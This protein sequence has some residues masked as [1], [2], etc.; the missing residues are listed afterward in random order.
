MSQAILQQLQQLQQQQPPVIPPALSDR[1][2]PIQGPTAQPD[3]S[4]RYTT[5]LRPSP[6]SD[7]AIPLGTWKLRLLPQDAAATA[8][9]GIALTYE[10]GTNGAFRD[11]RLDIARFELEADPQDLVPADLVVD[12]YIRL[13]PRS[14]VVRLLGPGLTLIMAGPGLSAFDVEFSGANGGIDAR[15]PSAR[16]S[17]P[18]F[19]IGSPSNEIGVAC[20][21]VL[22]DL[23]RD[24]TPVLIEALLGGAD[25]GFRGL[26]LEEL[27]LFIGDPKAVGTW[28]GNASLRDFIINFDPVQLTGTF[29]GEL[30]HA[31]AP[32]DPQVLVEIWKQDEDGTRV[33]VEDEGDATLPAPPANER[34]HRVR[35]VA[36]PNW[37]SAGFTATWTVPA[38]ATLE[39][40][41]RLQQLDLGWMRVGP[42]DY[43]FTV[44]VKD[45]RVPT[46][47]E[48]R[49]VI[50]AGPAAAPGETAPALE[51]DLSASVESPEPG[52]HAVHL[53][54]TLALSQDFTVRL[55]V[56]GGEGTEVNADIH[57][58]VGFQLLGGAGART[59]TRAAGSTGAFP[60]LTWNMRSG[61]GVGDNVVSVDATVGTRSVSRRLRVTVPDPEAPGSPGF[62]LLPLNDW[63]AA[64]GEGVVGVAVRD[65]LPYDAIHWTLAAMDAP[66][67]LQSDAAA[68][69]FFA[70]GGFGGDTAIDLAAS[71]GLVKPDLLT[72]G[73]LYRLTGGVS[74][75]PAGQ[76]PPSVFVGPTVL[77]G[78]AA[79]N[80]DP[81]EPLL[82]EQQ[83]RTAYRVGST[84]TQTIRFAFDNDQIQPTTIKSRDGDPTLGEINV[85]QAQGFADLYRAIVEF[86]DRVERLGL[87]GSA[88]T[89]GADDYNLGLAQRRLDSALGALRAPPTQLRTAITGLSSPL[90]MTSTEIAAAAAAFN[91]LEAA[92][93]LVS[94]SWGEQNPTDTNDPVDRRVFAV[95]KLAPPALPARS[96]RTYFL[97]RGDAPADTPDTPA[98]TLPAPTEHP[99][100]HAW[101]RSAHTEIELLRN[102]LVRFQIRLE[103]DF[104]RFNENDLD[105]AGPLNNPDGITTLFLQLRRDLS[106]SP[107]TWGWELDALA[108]PGDVDGF[109]ALQDGGTGD[110]LLGTAGGPAIALP[111]LTAV[112]G[113]RMGPTGLVTALAIGGFLQQEGI[114]DVRVLVWRGIRLKL[115]HG[116][117]A[118][119]RFS[120]AFDYDVQYAIDADLSH[121]GLPDISLRTD[122]S[123]P[124]KIGFRNVGVEII[125]LKTV[126]V[127]YDPSAGFRV[128][129]G[130]P[131]VF[132]LGEGLGRLLRVDQV[133]TGAGSPLWLE[134]ELGFALDVGIFSI[135]KLRIRISLESGKLF[136][137]DAAG[138]VH[139]D[140]SAIRL[141]DID[142]TISKIGIG[143]EVPGVLDGYG[144][145]GITS[146][147]P[148]ATLVEGEL[149][150]S[151]P[152]LPTLRNIFGALKIYTSADLRALYLALGAEFTPGLPIGNTGVSVYGLHGLLGVNMGRSIADPL[153][154]LKAPPVGVT[155][156]AKWVPARGSWAFGV[157]ATLGT[158]FD[159]GFCVNLKG[160]LLLELPGPRFVL[161]GQVQI[162]AKLP[163]PTSEPIGVLAVV[164]L[165]LEN[166]LLTIGIDMSL[167]SKPII[168]LRVPTEAYFN[169][170]DPR[171]WHLRFG[172]WDPLEKRI[173]VRV[174]DLFEA[175]GYFQI[176]GHGLHNGAL[177]LEGICIGA[178]AR[179]EIV[180]GVP[181]LLYLEA[182]AEA[183]AGL[184]LSPLYLEG[185]LSVGGSLHVGP[186]SIGADGTLTAKV[187]AS[188]PSFLV[189]KGEVC[190]EIDLW[191]TSIRKCAHFTLGDGDAETPDPDNPFAKA[192][193]LDRMT[194]MEITEDGGVVI[195]PLDAVF[196]LLFTSDIVDGRASPGTSL[197][198]DPIA[199][200]NQVSGDL[201]YEFTLT[202][203][204]VQ[205]VG[206]AALSGVQSA[207]APYALVS[208]PPEAADS[209]RTLRVLD[210]MPVAHPRQLDFASAEESTLAQLFERLCGGRKPPSIGCATFDEEPLGAR[211]QWL[212]D[213]GQLKPVR[214]IS[215]RAAALGAEALSASSGFEPPRVVTLVPVDFAGGQPKQHCLR[216]GHTG[217]RSPVPLLDLL[218]LL[219]LAPAKAKAAKARSALY[220]EALK[221]AAAGKPLP[222][223]LT[224]VRAAGAILI[225]LPD[226]VV[227]QA[228]FVIPGKL[229]GDS[230]EIVALGPDLDPL[231]APVPLGALPLIA[232]VA[233]PG[234]FSG[235]VARRFTW[236]KA[237]GLDPKPPVIRWIVIRAPG[238]PK[239]QTDLADSFHLIEV[240][241]ISLG[242]WLRWVNQEDNIATTISILQELSGI[243]AG[244]PAVSTQPLLAPG[245]EYEL[246]SHL[247][248]KRFRSATGADD[249][250]ADGPLEVR[251]RRFRADPNPPKDLSRYV[252]GTDPAGEEQP[253][254][255]AEPMQIRFGSNVVDRIFAAYGRQL[256]ARAKADHTGNVLLQP[257]QAAGSTVFVPLGSTE[258]EI[259]A[260]LDKLTDRCL[261]GNWLQLFPKTL[262]SFAEPLAP[263]T[264]Y[265]VALLPRPLS[266]P[267]GLTFK[268][269]DALLQQAFDG[270]QSVYRFDIRSSR[271]ASFAEHISAYRAATIGD[272]FLDDP[273]GV[274]AVAAG[275]TIAGVV[276]DDSIVDAFCRAAFGGPI[277]IPAAPEVFRLWV[278]GS[279]PD[280]WRCRGLLLDGPEPLL[281][282]AD[283]GGI[284]VTAETRR[285][286]HPGAPFFTGTPVAGFKVIAGARG[287][288]VFLLFDPGGATPPPALAVRLH[289]AG[290]AAVAPSDEIVA[291]TVGAVPAAMLEEV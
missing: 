75:G 156:T 27:G 266:E 86:G 112:S 7:L 274:D 38:G 263:N 197:V 215:T 39:N 217:E 111:A 290:G 133:S 180:W 21:E 262:T 208:G 227:V 10:P 53:Y 221:I 284:R 169:L 110:E 214:V 195:V 273:L 135:E 250:G 35:L 6:G 151:F 98:P 207:W 232:S 73:Q 252:A 33:L 184:Q 237:S 287:A 223:K 2:D 155:D 234:P 90:G 102:E 109:V 175:W 141:D 144:E 22:L 153:A 115:Q 225:R 15:F 103:V 128:D 189:L 126:E 93:K 105:P 132:Q 203:L 4:Q 196:H 23:R 158:V 48:T 78:T 46:Q 204:A 11:I 36:R 61:V 198:T 248:W 166:D 218:D 260:V 279:G 82:N 116:G 201:Y 70:D 219:P 167:V 216:L 289:D 12:P 76:H 72:T 120:F 148:G 57:V 47:T 244:E 282:K 77:L 192:V 26:F 94:A 16:F 212:L 154:W 241:G 181:H 97:V 276:K 106:T 127:F 251:S 226:V 114:F 270:G 31:V 206:G 245:A 182:F 172:Q 58:P 243:V 246:V 43:A 220:I 91:A 186:I 89:E 149:S 255:C 9:V 146:P 131:G 213:H 3:G 202:D 83:Q 269:W 107:P 137:P 222:D 37:A 84:E 280:T 278:P 157:G 130:D 40:P 62:E 125:D 80:A 147:S 32:V 286:A 17:P 142:I 129:I 249:D 60:T 118:P 65:G 5:A 18:H 64:S 8:R 242:E 168:E 13:I 161:A 68:D 92:G 138:V 54:L 113:G 96:R 183:H 291:L 259:N 236:T 230:G 162:F 160:T 150:L 119:S 163:L 164:M 288:R 71:G 205:R 63:L 185:S 191:L 193:A 50:V 173:T 140:A 104:E 170:D 108:D 233:E 20:D 117:Q 143:V 41:G 28:S 231:D 88:S 66:A 254:Y 67:A 267:G 171:D 69:G 177:D 253:H 81:V 272:L 136:A 268:Q 187:R 49:H 188:P 30:V 256:V 277:A 238:N 56:S 121:F 265:S 275:V 25:P 95:I 139:L 239:G 87:F 59:A 224:A 228:D 178:G 55:V 44:E 79:L 85:L 42:G 194:G 145:L 190:G 29:V 51:A 159:A 281:R 209:Q 74:S 179:I 247:N 165:D 99:F 34:T 285:V 100:R 176:E 134:V 211:T 200:R 235:H 210:W 124:I 123:R 152:A 229:R 271:Y 257:V 258:L 14:G 122:P 101:F 240:C 174:F 261:P 199:L 283:D 52:A 1:F 45:H 264:G 19:F 24:I